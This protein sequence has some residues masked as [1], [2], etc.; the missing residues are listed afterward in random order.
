MAATEQYDPPSYYWPGGKDYTPD[1]AYGVNLCHDS[2]FRCEKVQPGQSWASLF[3]NKMVREVVMRLN[4]TNVALDYRYTILIPRNLTN[5]DYMAYS[6]LPFYRNTHG[7]RLLFVN[8]SLFAFGAYD[9]DGSLL[10]W[11]PVSSG[12]DWCDDTKAS[13][14]TAVGTFSIFKIEGANCVSGTFPIDLSAGASGG[15]SMPYCMYYH[16]GFAIHGSTLSGF[17]NRSHGCVRLFNDDAQWLNE[18]FV[19]LGTQVIVTH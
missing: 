2:R 14:A 4:R 10:F 5:I 8:L 13:C 18:H 1:E 12:S 19:T 11:G 9:S 16:N 17:V 15:A 6:P 7:H 3:P